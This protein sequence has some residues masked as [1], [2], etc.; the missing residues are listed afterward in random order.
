MYVCGLL[1]LL[2]QGS[3]GVGSS[4]RALTLAEAVDL[5]VGHD[6]TIARARVL[7]DR[8][9]L[10][11]LR[12]DL[13][14]FSAT[15]D[16]QLEELWFAS[17]DG[18]SIGLGLSSLTARVS[19]PV[20]SGFRVESAV[21]RAEHLEAASLHD[22]EESRRAVAVAVARGYWAVR[23]LALMREVE[24]RAVERLV[25]AERT[26]QA[27]VEAGLVPP[28]DER[29]MRA[30]RMSQ[31][32]VVAS[33]DGQLAEA[34]TALAVALGVE[35]S[36]VPVDA[37]RV[38]PLVAVR[39]EELR[40]RAHRSRPQ[41]VAALARVEAERE[42]IVHAESGYYPTLSAYAA[43]DYGN[44]PALPG[45]GARAVPSSASPFE[46]MV[47]DVQLGA[48]LSIN[49][50]DTL[51]T[52]TAVEDARY[53]EQRA[54]REV[55]QV[56]RQ[57]DAEV[58]TARA[59][60]QRLI[61]LGRSLEPLAVVAEENVQILQRRYGSGEAQVFEVIDAGLEWVD[62]ERRRTEARAELTLASIELEM[63]VG[64]E[65]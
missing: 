19:V 51:R 47:A 23:K 63:S 11:T 16:A 5:A 35:G 34:T 12:A 39:D 33:L 9:S 55:E 58:R 8:A 50:F 61:A 45:A 31:E 41:L 28:I 1:L 40:T 18:D 2:A 15:V 54:L 48:V 17:S 22:V 59:R 65:R 38:S 37:P 7:E 26:A 4:T 43:A 14:R 30:R 32:A 64:E 21:A 29:R 36:L 49:L 6:P 3:S 20:F 44:N 60:V 10:A 27:R 57:V 42:G 25:S 56:R 53:Q 24:L 62:V 46:G 13:D 52:H